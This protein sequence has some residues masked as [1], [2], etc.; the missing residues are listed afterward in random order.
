MLV[1]LRGAVR[2]IVES[3][4]IL[5]GLIALRALFIG[6]V[7]VV[8]GV[9]LLLLLGLDELLAPLGVSTQTTAGFVG[10]LVIVGFWVVGL[11][12]LFWS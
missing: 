11:K 8:F 10:A 1:L 6:F 7:A 2:W 3:V 4:G 5:L 12:V 9:F